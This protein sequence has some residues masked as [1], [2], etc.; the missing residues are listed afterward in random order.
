MLF[1]F[2]ARAMHLEEWVDAAMN[3]FIMIQLNNALGKFRAYTKRWANI[4]L[5]FEIT[6]LTTIHLF[7]KIVILMKLKNTIRQWNQFIW[8]STSS[9][10]IVV[11]YLDLASLVGL[12]NDSHIS[13]KNKIK[14][15]SWK[16]VMD[17][18][19]EFKHL[20]LE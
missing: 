8:N 1:S 19:N 6:S 10:T 13:F 2:L 4:N 7:F 16:L 20:I 5:L 14:T 18:K 15:F 3:K 17:W 12:L 9:D 11:K